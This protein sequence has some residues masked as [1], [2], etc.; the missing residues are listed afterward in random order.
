ME[1]KTAF[2]SR[3][4]QNFRPTTQAVNRI[5][6][7]T[8]KEDQRAWRIAVPMPPRV[9]CIHAMKAS[10]L[11]TA[12]AF[13]LGFPEAEVVNLVDD[14]LSADVVSTGCDSRMEARFS[15]LGAYA[16]DCA[17]ADAILF[18]C[19]A[20]GSAIERVQAESSIPVLKPNGALQRDVVSR[21]GT[22]GVLSM[23]RPTL[24]SILRELGELAAAEGAALDVVPRFVEGA[25]DALQAGDEA[26]CAELIAADAVQML[27]EQPQISTVALAMFSM[28][29]AGPEVEAALARADPGRGG[30]LQVLTSPDA[31]V[32]ELRTLFASGVL[33]A[34]R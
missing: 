19:S 21:G 24:P 1:L 7:A 34:G 13:A 6:P 28:A 2:Y 17:S 15:A 22:V 5:P 16:R 18:T 3:S 30:G 20:F 26:R 11:P 29:F 23:F 25:L 31:A 9:V 14:S 32:A 27:A 8:R 4:Q 10:L 33:A 12:R